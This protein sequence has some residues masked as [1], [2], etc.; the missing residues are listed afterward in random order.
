[1]ADLVKK[2]MYSGVGAVSLAFD[3]LQSVVDGLIE[4][5][6]LSNKEGKK[7]V[8]EFTESLEGKKEELEGQIKK[9]TD[10]L[11]KKFEFKKTGELDSIKD[12]IARLENEWNASE[13]AAPANET[14]NDE[15]VSKKVVRK[16]AQEDT[17]E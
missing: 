5:E 11:S 17:A 4:Q 16:K 13:A 9:F 3:K 8:D 7:L 10:E 12:R 6:K 14:T 15:K 1:M 2:A